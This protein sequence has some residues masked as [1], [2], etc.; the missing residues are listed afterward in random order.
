[1]KYIL[2]VLSVLLAAG[3]SA[4]APQE[5]ERQ[6]AAPQP[7]TIEVMVLGVYHFANPGA[8]VHNMDA[9]N[10]LTEDK[11]RELDVLANA[12]AAFEPTKVAIEIE[13]P[14]PAYE[15]ARFLEFDSDMLATKANERIQIGYRLAS[16]MGHS[17]VYGIDEQ[18]GEGEPDYFPYG[19]LA[20]HVAETGQQNAFDAMN[21]GIGKMVAAFG[22]KQAHAS[23][24]ELLLEMN[25]GPM[26]GAEFYF[27]LLTYDEG[28]A[29]PAAELLGYW[30]MRNAKIFSKLLDIA[31]PG[32]R[33]VVVYG[34]GHKHWLDY[35]ADGMPGVTNVQPDAYLQSAIDAL[36]TTD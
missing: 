36:E 25:T 28:E 31:E 9:V 10:V 15:D 35:F 19:P 23:I 6:E 18:P 13:T 5:T 14:A 29:Q 2:I 27:N 3:C 21:S 24:P 7:D 20:A 17:R 30:H 11:Q 26:S 16:T 33:I 1:M 4:E 8:D 34:A 22:D 32:D 12:L